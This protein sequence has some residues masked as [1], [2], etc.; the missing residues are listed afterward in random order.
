MKKI[1]LAYDGTEPAKRALATASQLA[2]AFDA[3]VTVVS[4]VPM[5]AGRTP[6]DPWDDA[7]VHAREL[8][9]ARDLLRT[10]GIE[11]E[12]LEPVGDVP[13]RIE[14]VAR[15]GAFDVIVLGSRGLGSVGRFLQ[16][17]VSEHVATHADATVVIA[18]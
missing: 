14:T 4:V 1:L 18:H 16:G 5:H 11:A 2:R 17:S 9:E 6:V 8:L 7:D 13:D 3:A 12:L 10:D 15:R